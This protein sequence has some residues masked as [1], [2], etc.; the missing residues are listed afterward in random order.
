MIDKTYLSVNSEDIQRMLSTLDRTT[1]IGVRDY[2]LL[3]LL[4]ENSLRRQ[5]VSDA[6]IGDFDLEQASLKIDK[7]FHN[8]H[9]S[10]SIRIGTV[11]Y[12]ALQNWLDA[13]LQAVNCEALDSDQPLFIA[14]D[15]ASWGHRLTG[16]AIYKI[17][18]R[19]AKKLGILHSNLQISP[20]RIRASA[21]KPVLIEEQPTRASTI[22]IVESSFEDFQ[23]SMPLV[24]SALAKDIDLLTALLADKRS[25]NTKKAYE[26][27]LKYFF[28]AA[29]D[30]LPSEELVRQFLRL[31]RFDAIALVL[32][33]KSA[34]IAKD[35]KEATVNRR[36]SAI[37]SLVDYAGKLGH[38]QWNLN[39]VQGE[40]VQTYRDTTGIKTSG[41]KA[42][43]EVPNRETLAGKRDYAIL[44]LLWDNALRRNEIASA[45]IGDFDPE[46]RSLKI[47]GKGRGSQQTSI[48][49]SQATTVAIQAWLME[50]ES[51]NPNQPLFSA[52]D[53]ASY[54]H[55]LTGSAIYQLVNNAA[56][57]AGISKQMSP[58]RIRHSAITAA[59]DATNGNV[60]KVQK[61]SRHKKLDTL[62][63]Y[64]DNR[65]NAQGEISDLLSDLI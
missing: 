43:L 4:H 26:K 32:K 9:Q 38:C 23:E 41:I 50:I 58:H 39:E 15:R 27:D 18:A 31:D 7:K 34:M 60:R 42:M 55:R 1:L 56:K 35:L 22:A 52:L 44:R 17:T 37:K 65:T 33:Y 36:L 13:R 63:L 40:T 10:L 62:M 21:I 19:T 6:N 48:S 45:N 12:E 51:H 53:S 61:L 11:T 3:L 57:K 54:G 2:A 24:R 29:Y 20:D 30:R 46:M 25:I 47:L 16:T 49:L 59:L 14:L 5:Q 8:H 64:D 28:L